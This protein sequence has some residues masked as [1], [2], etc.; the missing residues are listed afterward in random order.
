VW[1]GIQSKFKATVNG[2][3]W[4]INKIIGGINWLIS[5]LNKIHFEIPDWVPKVGGKSFGINIQTVAE[6]PALAQGGVLKKSTLVNVG[7]YAG[8][9]TNPEIV[10]PQ[11]IMKET[12]M[13]A[14]GPLEW[15]DKSAVL[16][17]KGM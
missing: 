15:Y 5:G 12:V 1:D 14:N 7:E 10:A 2:I 4:L 3:I 16:K 9:A 6:I 8:A 13:D 17:R 11:S